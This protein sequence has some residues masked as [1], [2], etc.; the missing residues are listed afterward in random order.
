MPTLREAKAKQLPVVTNNQKHIVAGAEGHQVF[1]DTSSVKHR[2]EKKK[3]LSK[4]YWMMIVVELNN[5]KISEFLVKT[6][7]LPEKACEAVRKLK[8]E[9]VNVKYVRLDNAGENKVFATLANG[10]EWNLQL[11]FEFTGAHTLQRNYL[12]EVGFATLWGRL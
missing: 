10:K 4:P 8:L 3:L 7:E 5:F 1:I 2:S 11:Q 12:V 9:G 6:N